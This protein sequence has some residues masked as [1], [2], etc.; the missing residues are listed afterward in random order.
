MKNILIEGEALINGNNKLE[1]MYIRD[2][3]NRI[4]GPCHLD[5]TSLEGNNNQILGC[6]TVSNELKGGERIELN[7]DVTINE[8][9][10]VFSKERIQLQNFTLSGDAIYTNKT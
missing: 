8:F 3:G 5:N 4:E 7:G 2:A 6:A 10:A 9:A 1:E